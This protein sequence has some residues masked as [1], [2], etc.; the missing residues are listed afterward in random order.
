MKIAS[1]LEELL[2]CQWASI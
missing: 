2:H 1:S